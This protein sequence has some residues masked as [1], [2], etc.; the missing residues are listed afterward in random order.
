MEGLFLCCCWCCCCLTQIRLSNKHGHVCWNSN[1]RLPL[2][3]CRPRK[4]TS[5]F[6]FRLQHAN[7]SLPFPFSVSSV[8]HI[9]I[10]IYIL[11]DVNLAWL[12]HDCNQ[13]L[14]DS[15]AVTSDLSMADGQFL[16]YI[17]PHLARLLLPGGSL[18]FGRTNPR[19]LKILME[20]IK[21]CTCKNEPSVL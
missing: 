16:L 11:V 7:G 19:A 8:F 21:L 4:T 1:R 10:D 14:R 15:A 6:R 3:F 2:I 13:Q 9:Y 5:V 20:S 17:F 12:L 18:F